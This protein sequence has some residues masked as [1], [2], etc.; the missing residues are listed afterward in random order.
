MEHKENLDTIRHSLSHVM[1]AAVLQMFPEAKFGI[2]PSIENGF[3]YDFDLP[4]PLIP[5]DLALIDSKMKEIIKAGLEFEKVDISIADAT[6]KLSSSNQTYKTELIKDLEKEGEKTIS[7]YKTGE[8]IDLCRGPHIKSTGELKNVVFM[9]DKIAG[10]Y[11][12]GSEKNKMLQR[13]YALAF[14]SKAEL[15]KFIEQR[16][17]AEKRDHRKLGFQL[18]LF[19]FH[20]E[21]PGFP[22]W[23]P[24][25]MVVWNKLMDWW[26]E[27]HVEA[28]YVEVKTPVILSRKLWESSG[29]WDHYKENMY[30]T[31]IDERDFAVKPMNC[32]GSMLLYKEKLHSYREFPIRLAEVGLVHR[33]ELAGVLHGLLRV[34]AFHQDDAHIFCMPSQIES[35]IEGVMNLVDKM[36]KKFG[37]EYHLELSTRPTAGSIGSDEMWEK[38]E[39]SLKSVLDKSGKKYKLNPGDG[40]F[41][42]PKIDFHITDAIGRT[43]Q[44]GTIQLD[45]AMPEKFDLEYTAEDGSKQRPVMLHRV[46]LGSIERFLGIMIE[47]FG[48]AFPVWLAPVQARTIS[49]TERSAEYAFKIV[50]QLKEAG[51]RVEFD[52]RNE[53]LGKKIREAELNKIPYILI[54]GDK[55]LAENKIALR[56]FGQGDKGKFDVKEI[57]EQIKKG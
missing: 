19:S 15:D 5:E 12:K 38:A 26:R 28:S 47:H 25:G 34:R 30:F 8:F 51:I 37:F 21:A 50:D 23:H 22:F 31:K 17:E 1:A 20:D 18:D 9:L 29:H 11:W 45:F 43:W 36:Y 57:I 39:K 10:A 56:I 46:I 52:D 42:G 53:S 40:A 4:R 55:E 24:K 7:L 14:N 3:Y 33:H 32:P 35:E 27:E 6:K 49:I 54:V 2:G 41:Y 48:G 44:L 13:I 16:I